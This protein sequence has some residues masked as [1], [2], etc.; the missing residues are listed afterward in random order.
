MNADRVVPVAIEIVMN[1]DRVAPATTARI[2]APVAIEIVM[3]AG[4]VA[5]ATTVKI[6]APAALG[7]HVPIKR[8]VAPA[9]IE[10]G[11]IVAPEPIVLEQDRATILAH[12]A[13]DHVSQWRVVS[14]VAPIL[15]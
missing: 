5:P 12:S 14:V 8:I 13:L 10:R 6:A 11:V 3:N 15:V 4:K 1:A 9:A 7:V 2:V